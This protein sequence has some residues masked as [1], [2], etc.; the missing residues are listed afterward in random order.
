MQRPSIEDYEAAL[1]VVEYAISIA[2]PKNAMCSLQKR[3]MRGFKDF[4]DK[5]VIILAERKLK[6]R[7]TVGYLM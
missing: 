6:E 3:W 4:R 7:G 1:R 2:P 5:V